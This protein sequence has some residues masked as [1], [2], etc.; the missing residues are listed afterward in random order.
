M[1]QA[2]ICN[3]ILSK[4]IEIAFNDRLIPFLEKSYLLYATQFGFRK[5]QSTTDAWWDT[6]TVDCFEG[7]G[8]EFCSTNQCAKKLEEKSLEL[9]RCYFFERTQVFDYE[10]HTN[11]VLSRQEYHRDSFWAL[12]NLYYTE[13]SFQLVSDVYWM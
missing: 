7:R 12:S 2:I 9:F 4:P 6:L 8:N 13:T 1:I 11:S 5:Q 10:G 3:P